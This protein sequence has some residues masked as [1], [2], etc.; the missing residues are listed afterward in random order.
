MSDAKLDEIKN[1][2]EDIRS[3]LKITNQDKIEE[4]KKKLIRSGSIEEKIFKLCDG[5]NTTSD[6]A[7]KIQKT[8]D[9]TRASISS[10]R[11][12]GLLRTIEKN[13]KQVHVQRF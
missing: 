2:L 1:L 12:K 4:A 9:Y 7:K 10:L 13:N 5:T 6:I 3:L 11:E 8:N